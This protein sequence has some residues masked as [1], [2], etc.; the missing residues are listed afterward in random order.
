MTIHDDTVQ[1]AWQIK[2]VILHT[3]TKY[4]HNNL[5]YFSQQQQL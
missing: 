3:E 5:S 4:W 2:T 1:K